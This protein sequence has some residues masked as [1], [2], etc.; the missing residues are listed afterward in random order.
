MIGLDRIAGWFNPG[1]VTA[2]AAAGRTLGTLETIEAD[3]VEAALENGTAEVIDV[4]GRSEWEAGHLPGVR[5]IPLT[6]LTDRLSEIPRD[7]PIVLHCQSGN[8]S[9]IASSV[10][11]AHGFDKTSNYAG[12]F[13][14]WSR[15]GRPV[16]RA[17]ESLV[18]DALRSK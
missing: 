6:T 16:H 18:D 4:R 17:G 1:A 8:R 14:G 15:A 9:I 13:S 5:N 7:R 11:R 12:G 3:G 2:W 10:L